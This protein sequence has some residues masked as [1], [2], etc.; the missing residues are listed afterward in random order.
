MPPREGAGRRRGD[1]RGAENA[2]SAAAGLRSC[3]PRGPPPSKDI[4]VFGLA[5]PAWAGRREAQGGG[6][7]ASGAAERA[8]LLPPAAMLFWP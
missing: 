5:L 6:K 1:C 8:D 4:C 7:S 3:Q 2:S